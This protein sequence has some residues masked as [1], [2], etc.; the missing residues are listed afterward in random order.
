MNFSAI[1]GVPFDYY[2]LTDM[3]RRSAHCSERHKNGLLYIK[4]FHLTDHITRVIK[5]R[6]EPLPALILTFP[7]APY[8]WTIPIVP[9]KS[10]VTV[11]PDHDRLT[12]F[13]S[14]LESAT[15][16]YRE[17]CS[18]KSQGLHNEADIFIFLA[19]AYIWPRYAS[20]LRRDAINPDIGSLDSERV[21]DAFSRPY[22]KDDLHISIM[23]CR[24]VMLEFAILANAAYSRLIITDLVWA[25][26][27]KPTQPES[28]W[29]S[30]NHGRFFGL[31][32][33]DQARWYLSFGLAMIR[34]S[35]FWTSASSPP[36]HSARAFDMEITWGKEYLSLAMANFP[37][38]DV[39]KQ[40][41]TT[42]IS[43]SRELLD[44]GVLNELSL[45][46]FDTPPPQAHYQRYLDSQGGWRTYIG[47]VEIDGLWAENFMYLAELQRFTIPCVAALEERL[48]IVDGKW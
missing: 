7:A 37:D 19:D 26:Q 47:D 33:L 48:G 29:H 4:S 6:V 41:I 46:S 21:I 23:Q 45:Q 43:M 38:N 9:I 3:L 1:V 12:C 2:T 42:S 8:P 13:E 20:Y 15:L 5:E 34:C 40:E 39:W 28:S 14:I 17:Y 10:D 25:V 30:M 32:D 11:D 27:Y 18:L 24:K 44:P 22:S 16:V 35:A 36:A 31:S